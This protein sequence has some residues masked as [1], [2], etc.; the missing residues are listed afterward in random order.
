M[1]CSAKDTHLKLLDRAVSVAQFLIR[2]VF[3]CDAAHRLSVAV[4][5][6][7]HKIECNPMH[8]LNDALLRP[9]VPVQVTRGALV[10]H[11]YLALP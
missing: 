3:E 10:A 4:M 8:P 6:M 5:C 2:G 7:L 11:R 9:Y 1:W